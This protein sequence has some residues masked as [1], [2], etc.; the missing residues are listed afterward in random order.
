MIGSKEISTKKRLKMVADT[1]SKDGGSLEYNLGKV[2]QRI[3]KKLTNKRDRYIPDNADVGIFKD[4]LTG[5]TALFTPFRNSAGRRH[6]GM[7]KLKTVYPPGMKVS[8]S[9]DLKY[10]DINKKGYTKY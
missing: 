5:L 2:E 4:K 1:V 3:K 10:W 6:A 7:H 9:R 8:K